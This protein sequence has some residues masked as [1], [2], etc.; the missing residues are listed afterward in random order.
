MSTITVAAIEPKPKRSIVITTEGR[1]LGCW[2]DKLDKLGI[3]AGVTYNVE[4]VDTPVGDGGTILTNITTARRIT[5]GLPEARPSFRSGAY[6]PPP[7]SALASPAASGAPFRTPE[8]MFVEGVI[9]AYI[10]NGRCDP[11]K[12]TDIIGFVRRAWNSH[13]GEPQ[14]AAAE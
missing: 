8:Q 1:R 10:G 2:T 7:G 4:T 5:M 3:E 6:R 14:R 11:E 13:W 9:T 12:L